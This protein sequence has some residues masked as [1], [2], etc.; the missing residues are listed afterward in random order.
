M[1]QA[2]LKVTTRSPGSRPRPWAF[3]GRAPGQFHWKLLQGLYNSCEGW[4]GHRAIAKS[5]WEA[6]TKGGPNAI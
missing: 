4:L 1:R 3:S 6:T 2:G 5:L